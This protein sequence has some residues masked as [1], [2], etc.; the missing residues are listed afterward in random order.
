MSS[1]NQPAL[2]ERVL[3]PLNTGEGVIA[4]L[5][6]ACAFTIPCAYYVLETARERLVLDDELTI[7]ATGAMA[8]LFVVVVPVYG[9]LATRI[10]RIRL[11][12]LSYTVLIGGLA[13]LVALGLAGGLAVYLWLGLITLMLGAQLWLYASSTRLLATL[14]IGGATGATFGSRLVSDVPGAVLLLV[15]CLALFNVD[16]HLHTSPSI[17]SPAGARA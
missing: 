12:N 5:V 9:A 8:M 16:A 13:L 3:G 10:G 14:A 17:A 15:V 1:R 11:V 6:F 7:Y 2:I 4:L